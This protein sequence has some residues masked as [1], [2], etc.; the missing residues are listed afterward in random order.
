MKK[1]QLATLV[2]FLVLLISNSTNAQN[3]IGYI[4]QQELIASMP[5]ARK[6]DSILQEY[7]NVLAQTK[8]SY[9]EDYTQKL[10][11]FLSDSSKMSATVK[12]V[13]KNKLQDSYNKIAN[14]NQEAEGKYRAKEQELTAPIFEKAIKAIQASA[15]EGGYGYVLSKETLLVYPNADDLLPVV[16]K[17]LGIKAPVASPNAR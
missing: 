14:Y 8:Q 10:T 7:Q 12:E 5:E 11:K 15:K 4:S 13:E 9:E 17:K 3:K 2:T 1:L 6:A 16:R